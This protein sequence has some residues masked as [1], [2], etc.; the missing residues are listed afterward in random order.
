[1]GPAV[2]HL[3]CTCGCESWSWSTTTP[4]PIV[5]DFRAAHERRG[6]T[7]VVKVERKRKAA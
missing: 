5:L 2:T 3:A 4:D 6:H 7:V 1:M